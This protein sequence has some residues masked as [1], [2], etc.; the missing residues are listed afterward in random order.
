[1]HL[2][3]KTRGVLEVAAVIFTAALYFV[4]CYLVP[5]RGPFILLTIV[6]WS[7]YVTFRLRRTPESL[8]EFG[9][10]TH[11]LRPSTVAASV[12]LVAGVA[13]CLVVGL[14]HGGVR[15]VPHM[16]VLALLYPFWGLLQQLL[17]QAM[18]VRN[19]APIVS[20]RIVVAIAGVLSGVVHLPDLALALPTTILGA[21][22]TLLFLRWRNIWA[23]GV[24]HGWLG[25]FFYYWVL[26]RDP[27]LE[28]VTGA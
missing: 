15:F 1:M 4:F 24:C 28:I 10:S 11:G 21:I 17:I 27:W 23:L 20:P 12:V 9:L 16:F 22:F 26:G 14:L 18:V 25:V 13:F 7:T 8:R 5:G 3:L 6:A 2:G 19:L